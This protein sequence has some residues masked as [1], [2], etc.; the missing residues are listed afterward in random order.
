M[1]I[2]PID[3]CIIYSIQKGKFAED[4]LKLHSDRVV[5]LNDK[6]ENLADTAAIMTQMDLVISVDTVVPHLAGA[7]AVKVWTLLSL[8]PFWVYSL[9]SEKCPWYPTMR[10][11]N[12]KKP[13]DWTE[14]ME[15]IAAELQQFML[16]HRKLAAVA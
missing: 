9:D 7:L 8:N 6:I 12:Q 14:V 10:I 3:S 11:F 5:D 16:E 2:I 1:S 15:Q 13:F 4:Q